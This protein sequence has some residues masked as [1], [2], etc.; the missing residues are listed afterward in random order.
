M[1]KKTKLS[2]FDF[3]LPEELIA[4]EPSSK[5]DQSSLLV[6]NLKGGD[7]KEGNNQVKKIYKFYEVID[8][9]RESDLVVF[10][11]SKVIN[12]QLTLEKGAARIHVNLN[13]EMESGVWG[14]FAKPGRKLKIGD[15]FIYG[16]SKN[17]ISKNGIRKNSTSKNHTSNNTIN[18]TSNDTSKNSTSKIVISKKDE[19]GLV[20]FRF[21]FADGENI[22]TFLEKYGEV[23]LPPYIKRK[24]SKDEDKERYQSVLAKNPGS[25]AAPTASLHFTEELIE[26]IK[27]KGTQIEFVTLH[28]G[29]G[30]YLPVKT[31]N[32]EEH[33]MH[34]ELAQLEEDVA[35]RINAAKK[36]GRRVIAV[37]STAMRTLE[38]FAENGKLGFGVRDT[39]IFIKPG[40]R[41]NIADAMITNFHL[42]K[43]TLFML[44]CA[45]AGFREMHAAY[46]YAIKN[47]LRFFSYGDAMMIFKKE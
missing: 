44:V 17:D 8:Q 15:E 24:E 4:Q 30:T 35:E 16:A 36:E 38:T 32:I 29:A 3:D 11:N 42:P 19:S 41:F 26:R 7:H 10:N 25:V 9:I 5:R 33:L 12:A 39:N 21:H 46:K 6:C 14:G 31:E 40:Y 47:K 45:F 20:Y 1:G 34:S 13:R 28:V 18:D 2:D 23:P 37:G 22:F 27:K 43:S